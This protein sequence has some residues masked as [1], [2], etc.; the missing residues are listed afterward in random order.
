[1]SEKIGLTIC[2]EVTKRFDILK[3]EGK[4]MSYDNAIAERLIAF[5]DYIEYPYRA[6]NCPHPCAPEMW[7]FFKV[8]EEYEEE[9]EF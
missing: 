7:R 8:E 2:E 6:E 9:R 3:E 5:L 4:V 1:M